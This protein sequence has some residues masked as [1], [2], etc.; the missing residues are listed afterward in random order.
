MIVN[1]ECTVCH[2]KRPAD[3]TDFTDVERWII[4][5]LACDDE[6]D[7]EQETD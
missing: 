7:D 4:I 1:G 6:H 3:S 2:S 5:H